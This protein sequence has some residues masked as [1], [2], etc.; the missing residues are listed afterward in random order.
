MKN[1]WTGLNKILMFLI[2]QIAGILPLLAQENVSGNTGAE[3]ATGFYAEGKI[4]IVIGVITIILA[5]I[6]LYLFRI[7]NK[8]KKMEQEIN[9]K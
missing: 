6:I 8:I 9:N 3:M 2:L 7:D 4:Y 1:C 5:G